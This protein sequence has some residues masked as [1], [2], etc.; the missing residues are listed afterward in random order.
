MIAE[1]FVFSPL[2]SLR[3]LAFFAFHSLL[4]FNYTVRKGG[5]KVAERYFGDEFERRL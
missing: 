2:R 4:I 3:F 5:V 1:A